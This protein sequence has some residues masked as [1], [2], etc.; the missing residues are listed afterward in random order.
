MTRIN[1]GVPFDEIRAS[2]LKS[3]ILMAQDAMEKLWE[4]KTNLEELRRTLPYSSVEQFR[5]YTNGA[6][7]D[8]SM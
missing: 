1:K 8:H 2:A 7:P 3:T 5:A 6:T 4:G